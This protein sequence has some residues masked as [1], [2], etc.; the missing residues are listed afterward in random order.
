MATSLRKG[1][2]YTISGISGGVLFA[3]SSGHY[4]IRGGRGE[5]AYGVHMLIVNL[6]VVFGVAHISSCNQVGRQWFPARGHG[7]RPPVSVGGKAQESVQGPPGDQ[8]GAH[9]GANVWLQL[10]KYPSAGGVCP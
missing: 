1:L 7:L 9:Y 2:K 5:L 4:S 10:A 8:C 3:S 6:V